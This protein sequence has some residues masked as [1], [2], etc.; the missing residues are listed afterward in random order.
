[1]PLISDDNIIISSIVLTDQGSTPATPATGKT[2]LYSKTDGLH[3]VNDAGTVT[4]LMS[5]PM[6]TAGDTIY[7]GASGVPTRL[8]GGAS[9]YVLTSNGATSAPSWQAPAGGSSSYTYTDEKTA[10][11]G[12]AAT[13][14][15]TSIPGTGRHLV[16]EALVRGAKSAAYDDLN[17]SING[18]ETG[19]YYDFERSI[20]YTS[21]HAANQ[22]AAGDYWAVVDQPPAASATAG[23]TTYLRLV[24]PYYANT[25]FNKSARGSFSTILARSSGSIVVGDLALFCAQTTAITSVKLWFTGGNIAQ[26]S[27]ASLYLI[28]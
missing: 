28:G 18:V 6:T 4:E 20:A 25:T 24:F 11:V 13:F 26:G 19:G 15:F 1:M 3:A 23:L 5:N 22:L 10:G 12:G 14:N 21:S 7:G 2:R 9:G 16:I 27:I 17:I 8:A